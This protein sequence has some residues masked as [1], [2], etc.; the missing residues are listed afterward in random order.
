M[1]IRL[2]KKIII[3]IL[4]L[5]IILLG[6]VYFIQEESHV[7]I[8]DKAYVQREKIIELMPEYKEYLA[9]KDKLENLYAQEK[10]DNIYQKNKNYNIKEDIS[11]YDNTFIDEELAVKKNM[12]RIDL[13]ESYYRYIRQFAGTVY[14]EPTPADLKIVNLQLQLLGLELEPQEKQEKERELSKLLEARTPSLRVKDQALMSV[15]MN[16]MKKE[17]KLA[18]EDFWQYKN[19]AESKNQESFAVHVNLNVSEVNQINQLENMLKKQEKIVDKKYGELITA[20]AKNEN[21]EIV[22]SID[23]K[24]ILARDITDDVIE[25]MKVNGL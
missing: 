16:C 14:S 6:C 8:L 9:I 17:Q 12:M 25:Y 21:L 2:D 1:Q 3:S 20:V 23:N 4:T 24:D 5:L 18:Q 22:E 7:F 19:Q 11:W 13:I 15:V 10:A